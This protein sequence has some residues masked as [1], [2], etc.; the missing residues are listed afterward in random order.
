MI[1]NFLQQ[2]KKSE[3]MLITTVACIIIFIGYYFL[4][5]APIMAKFLTIARE[6]A[7]VESQLDKAELS[8]NRMPTIQK[9]IEELKSKVSF[10]SNKL[11][12][13]EE[14]P[15]ILENLSNMAQNAGVKIIKIRPI[16]NFL[17]LSTESVH[18]EIYRQEEVSIDALC[19]YHQL[20]TFIAELEN[21]E[22]FME[23]S[24]IRVE[25]TKL[26]P[27]R[28]NVQLIVKTFILKE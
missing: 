14:F 26:S 25:S 2:A 8:I 28:H 15:A 16:K 17:T 12:K 1:L 20:G 4:F 19:G 3:L 22:R 7:R 9:E 10:Y 23:V 5:L 21:A 18:P 13:E 6:V 27:K 24:H 11:P